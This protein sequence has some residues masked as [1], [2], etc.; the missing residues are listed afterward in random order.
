MKVSKAILKSESIIKF[1]MVIKPI[2]LIPEINA[3][4]NAPCDR[5]R[6]EVSAMK[7]ISN[8]EVKI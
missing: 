7:I 5:V 6:K 8:P 3:I 1:T 2:E 4:I